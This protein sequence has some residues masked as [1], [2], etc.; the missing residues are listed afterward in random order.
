MYIAEQFRIEQQIMK[1]LALAKA[2]TQDKKKKHGK[3]KKQSS[4][5][6]KGG[7]SDA[8]KEPNGKG[9]NPRKGAKPRKPRP[10]NETANSTAYC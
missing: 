3:S 4:A 8:T 2:S 5:Q 7:K 1:E 10:A 6:A 9:I